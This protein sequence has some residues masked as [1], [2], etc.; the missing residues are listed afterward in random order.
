MVKDDIIGVPGSRRMKHS[1]DW[2]DNTEQK[3]KKT[4]QALEREKNHT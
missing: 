4:L 2:E 1:Q 3:F